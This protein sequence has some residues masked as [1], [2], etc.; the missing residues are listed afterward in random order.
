MSAPSRLT[1]GPVVLSLLA[2]AHPSAAYAQQAKKSASD[3][4]TNRPGSIPQRNYVETSSISKLVTVPAIC[5]EL[6]ISPEFRQKIIDAQRDAVSFSQ[7]QQNNRFF[8]NAFQH[9]REAV[10]SGD[11][12]RIAATSQE[13]ATARSK[14]AQATA[15][16][17][18]AVRALLTPAQYRRLFQILVRQEGIRALARRELAEQVGLSEDQLAEFQEVL[19]ERE[20]TLQDWRNRNE[21]RPD[22]DEFAEKT[23]RVIEKSRAQQ[24]LT[25]EDHLVLDEFTKRGRRNE[26]EL[27]RFERSV[28]VR[29][30]RVLTRYQMQRF[31]RLLGADF[32]L[33]RLTREA[34]P[35]QEPKPGNQG[36][37]Q[38]VEIGKPNAV[39]PGG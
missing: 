32:D 29:L 4:P 28:D 39:R 18:Q 31:N 3:I 9:W 7:Q 33:H 8:R 1:I 24:L 11:E 25:K 35:K 27:D 26:E 14:Q 13:M 22:A 19:A 2:I 10:R 6:R 5:E 21:N 16:C 38:K 12:A 23:Q 36:E 30:A 17:D 37:P 20:K 15:A 34:Q